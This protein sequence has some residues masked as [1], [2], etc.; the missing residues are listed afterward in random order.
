MSDRMY[1]LTLHRPWP[2]GIFHAGK[3]IENREQRPPANLLGKDIAIH[4]GQ[5]WD[6][7]GYSMINRCIL[8]DKA[9]PLRSKHPTGIIGVVNL[10]GYVE[11][12]MKTCGIPS[13]RMWRGP[14]FT[15]RDAPFPGEIIGNPWFIGEVGLI[16]RNPRV[17]PAPVACPG[18]PGWW[19]LPDAVH[20]AVQAGLTG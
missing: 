19:R 20:A 15:E 11:G 2:W 3:D 16:L 14:V 17:L 8:D 1:A 12:Y 9:M 18:E 13:I 5:K 10:A 4:A 6:D 7:H